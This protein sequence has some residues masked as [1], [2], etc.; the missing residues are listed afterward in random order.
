MRVSILIVVTAVVILIIAVILITIFGGGIERFNFIWGGFS[1]DQ[2]V[3]SSCKT[4]CTE[5][6]YSTGTKSGQPAG[7]GSVQVGG[8][9]YQ[10]SEHGIS[11]DCAQYIPGGLTPGA[12]TK[13]PV[14][15][16]C[17]TDNDCQS[18]LK[19]DTTTNKCVYK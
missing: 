15:G 5:L 9:T 11:C 16:P 6:C 10:C 1:T 18:G 14:G 3:K 19:C 17:Q 8:A 4:R 13:Q 2:L 12:S 7:W